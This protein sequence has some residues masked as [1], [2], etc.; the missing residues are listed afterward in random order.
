V[1]PWTI[2]CDFSTAFNTIQ[3]TCLRHMISAAQMDIALV[4]W[5]TD[6]LAQTVCW[7]NNITTRD[8]CC[9]HQ[10][11]CLSPGAQTGPSGEENAIQALS[12]HKQTYTPSPCSN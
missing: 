4:S 9:D 7:D 6:L 8:T 1:A 11:G 5:I 10:E 12:H 3:P 2:F